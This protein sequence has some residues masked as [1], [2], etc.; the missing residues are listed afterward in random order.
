MWENDSCRKVIYMD[1]AQG[2]EQVNN[3]CMK[4]MPM[5]TVYRGFTYM[6]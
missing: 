5:G 2:P 4:T 6:V 1:N 3:T